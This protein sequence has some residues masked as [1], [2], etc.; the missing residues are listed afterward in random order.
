MNN[1]I[2][3]IAVMLFSNNLFAQHHHSEHSSHKLNKLA[4]I[5]VMSDHIHSKGSLMMSYSYM[6]M[7]M[8][9]LI[10]GKKDKSENEY[11]SDTSF[12]MAPSKMTTKM[13]M[14]GAMFALSDK[15]SLMAMIP[16]ISNKMEM[17]KKMG[18]TKV[19]SDSNSIGDISLTS[20][21][22]LFEKDNASF[23]MGIGLTLP[24]GQINHKKSDKNLPYGMQTGSGSYALS[25]T[26]TYSKS[27]QDWL[28][29]A[30]FRLK[31]YLNENTN[32]YK[33]GNE[34]LTNL[35][36]QRILPYDFESSLR[37]SQKNIDP[38]SSSEDS[39]S[40]MSSGFS[41]KAQHGMRR[42]AYVGLGYTG[43]SGN[44]ISMEFGKSIAQD[45]SGYQ[46]K[47]DNMF[48]LGIQKLF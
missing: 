31:S 1:T 41:P 46:L 29:G 35:W 7:E 28:F 10:N 34:Y 8:D 3:L 11:F 36:V 18:R 33:K 21:S 24:T 13:H 44:K 38:L 37:I 32:D 20:L 47:S 26:S 45:L 16:Q 40:T 43:F 39:I 25:I 2:V 27:Y 17:I 15:F 6:S 14:I 19:K 30:Q 22:K 5:G 23:I 9:G 4:P 48:M 12:M 42:F